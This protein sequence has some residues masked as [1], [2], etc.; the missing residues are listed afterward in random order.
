VEDGI[1]MNYKTNNGPPKVRLSETLP[2]TFFLSGAMCSPH[3]KALEAPLWPQLLARVTP[4]RN[5]GPPRG[6]AVAPAARSRNPV[7]QQRIPP[8]ACRCRPRARCCGPR[9]RHHCLPTNR[10]CTA[11]GG[12]LCRDFHPGLPLLGARRPPVRRCPCQA[13]MKKC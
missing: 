5:S 13:H 11:R 2:P 8:L 1:L 9:A 7:T 3:T 4:S 6:V 10:L 12:L